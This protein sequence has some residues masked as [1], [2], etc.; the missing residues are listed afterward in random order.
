MRIYLFLHALQCKRLDCHLSEG[1][2][3]DRASERESEREP[4]TVSP[5]THILPFWLY[6]SNDVMLLA[7]CTPHTHPLTIFLFFSLQSLTNSLSLYLNTMFSLSL[8]FSHC[9]TPTWADTAAAMVQKTLVFFLLCVNV[10]KTARGPV[11]AAGRRWCGLHGNGPKQRE[12][13][14]EAKQLAAAW[15]SE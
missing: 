1:E 9:A 4:G 2:T 3:R 6:S 15:R 13:Q 11:P 8:S 5:L 12:K 10:T 14:R 7:S